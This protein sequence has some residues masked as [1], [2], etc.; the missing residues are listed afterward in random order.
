MIPVVLLHRGYQDYLKYSILQSLQKNNVI[1]VGDTDPS[2]KNENFR[3][4]ELNSLLENVNDFSKLYVHMNTTHPDYE[5]FCYTRWFTI[6]N[7]MINYNLPIIFYI[8]SDVLFFENAGKEWNKFDQ[9]DM[10]LLHRTAGISSFI[11]L[12]G[13][14]NFCNMLLDIYS[15]KNEYHFNKIASHLQV[16]QRFGLTGGVC[17][18][19]LLEYFHYHAEFGGGP[20]RVGEMMTIIDGSTYDHNINAQDQDFDFKDGKKAVKIIE[21][22][23]YVFNHK[24]QKDIRFNSLH[25]QGG[26]KP[27]MGRIYERCVEK[28]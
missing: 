20:G 15:K 22:K 16:R 18:M 4:I 21:N 3:Y 28:K 24:L 5:L 25:L 27:M 23:P 14:T 8:D 9:Y 13:I 10:T 1:L 26:A 17:D 2:I 12:R 7:L 11:T 6:R 19:T